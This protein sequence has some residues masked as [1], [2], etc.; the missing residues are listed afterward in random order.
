M[1]LQID[2][3]KSMRKI[4]EMKGQIVLDSGIM[5]SFLMLIDMLYFRFFLG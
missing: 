1:W 3:N 2:L 4:N 5:G